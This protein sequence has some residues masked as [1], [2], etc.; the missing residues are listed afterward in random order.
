MLSGLGFC[1]KRMTLIYKKD[2]NWT[3]QE[4]VLTVPAP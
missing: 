3:D 4:E 1:S 2:L